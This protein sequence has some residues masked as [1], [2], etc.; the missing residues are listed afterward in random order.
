MDNTSLIPAFKDEIVV[1]EGLRD[2]RNITDSM[3][4]N[5]AISTKEK[6][7]IT[8][9][10]TSEKYSYKECDDNFE[11]TSTSSNDSEDNNLEGV[12]YSALVTIVI[13]ESGKRLV[14]KGGK[15]LV[16]K[17][18]QAHH[19]KTVRYPIPQIH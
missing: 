6:A 14:S 15:W 4:V 18:K 19:K 5:K 10:N 1:E 7:N 2:K 11:I 3:L 12:I 16:S 9:I 13:W 17:V 8:P